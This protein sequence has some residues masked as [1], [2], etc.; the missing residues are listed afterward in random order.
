MRTESNVMPQT[1]SR[2]QTVAQPI[3]SDDRDAWL[4]DVR[5]WYYGG[6]A[7]TG[8]HAPEQADERPSDKMGPRRTVLDDSE[9]AQTRA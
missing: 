3:R 8:E 5:R 9:H 4:E 7:P 1:S 6:M 2:A